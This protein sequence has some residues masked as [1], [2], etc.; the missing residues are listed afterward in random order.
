MSYIEKL[1][2]GDRRTIGQLITRVENNLEE[3]AE[4][5]KEIYPYTGKAYA[6]GVT[7]SPGSGKSTFITALT[8]YLVDQDKKVGIVAVDPSSPFT[9]GALLGDRIRMKE[10]FTTPNVF[11]R[12]MASRG[13]LGGIARATKDAIK[14][15]DAAGYDYIIVETVGVGQSEID[16]YKTVQTCAVLVAPNMGDDI[17]ALKAGIMEIT[18]VFI[19]NKADFNGADKQVAEIESMLDLDEKIQ[20]DDNRHVMKLVRTKGWRPPVLK[21][22]STTGEGIEQFMDAVEAHRQ[23]QETGEGARARR[24][25]QLKHE[26]IDIL[27]DRLSVKIETLIHSSENAEIEQDCDLMLDRQTDPYSVAK[28][29]EKM[30]LRQ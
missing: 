8:R 18:D 14:I 20:G 1:L 15:L 11:I 6:I 3:S 23:F 5:I 25:N 2:Q 24:R 19:V 12:S 17:Q 21:M 13:M 27:K 22:I 30:I 26:I 16:V 28:I 7:G 4:V 9:G 10:H 29:V